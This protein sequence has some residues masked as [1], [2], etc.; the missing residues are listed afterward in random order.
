[1]GEIKLNGINIKNRSVEYEFEISEDLKNFFSGSDKERM[2]SGSSDGAYD[3]VSAG[4]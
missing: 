1:M 2:E 4:F 3:S